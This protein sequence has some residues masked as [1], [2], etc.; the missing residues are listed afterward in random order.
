[1]GAG[2]ARAPGA[3][4]DPLLKVSS[5]HLYIWIYCKSGTTRNGY[6]SV[7]SNKGQILISVILAQWTT[8]GELLNFEYLQVRFLSRFLFIVHALS[9]H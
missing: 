8:N 3:P 7:I 5:L 9:T 1:M 6:I 2:G 4:L